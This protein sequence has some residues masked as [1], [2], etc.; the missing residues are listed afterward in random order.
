MALESILKELLICGMWNSLT[1]LIVGTL[2]LNY[3]KV[4]SDMFKNSFKPPFSGTG[5]LNDS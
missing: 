2:P 1:F 5:S 4:R 3:F